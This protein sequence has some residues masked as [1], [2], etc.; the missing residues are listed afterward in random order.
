MKMGKL[1]KVKENPC[2]F[3]R[4][5]EKY[6]GSFSVREANNIIIPRKKI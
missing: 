3:W 5:S 2:Y 4:K 6:M 1:G